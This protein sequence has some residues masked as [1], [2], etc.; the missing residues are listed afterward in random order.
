M[1]MAFLILFQ[2][3]AAHTVC[4]PLVLCALWP[5]DPFG[6]AVDAIMIRAPT[7]LTWRT[8]RALHFSLVAYIAGRPQLLR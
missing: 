8:T 4:S 1:F 5:P 3:L 7:S 6:D 2:L